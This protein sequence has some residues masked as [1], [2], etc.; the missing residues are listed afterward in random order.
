MSIKAECLECGRVYEVTASGFECN[1]EPEPPVVG[2]TW[3]Q[4]A[5]DQYTMRLEWERIRDNTLV[6][7]RWLE[8]LYRAA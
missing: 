1:H 5:A 7:I 4:M 3:V 8:D 6:E 2:H